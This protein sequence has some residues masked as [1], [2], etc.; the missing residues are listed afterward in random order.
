M[1]GTDILSESFLRV[2]TLSIGCTMIAVEPLPTR[3]L[4]SSVA[5]GTMLMPQRPKR[6]CA[7]SGCPNLVQPPERYCA[8]HTCAGSHA[9]DKYRGSAASRG[10]DAPWRRYTKRYL[11]AHPLCVACQAQ[12]VVTASSEVDHIVS[13]TGPDDPRFWDPSNHQALCKSCHSRKT[14]R[15]NR[16]FGNPAKAERK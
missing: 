14:A 12:G 11:K 9:Y 2:F 10:Y 13:V 8:A 6:P 15:E 7:H 1:D 3:R 16:G 5:E 4:L